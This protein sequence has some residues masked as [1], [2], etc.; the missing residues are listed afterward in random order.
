MKIFLGLCDNTK[1]LIGRLLYGSLCNKTGT[2]THFVGEMTALPVS[3]SAQETGGCG[4][5]SQ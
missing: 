2:H 1:M 5:I 3:T 4:E